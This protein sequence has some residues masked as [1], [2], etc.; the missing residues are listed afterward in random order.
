VIYFKKKLLVVPLIT[1]YPEY[2]GTNKYEEAIAFIAKKFESKHTR[3]KIF[4]HFTSFLDLNSTQQVFDTIESIVIVRN[5]EDTGLELTDIGHFDKHFQTS[6]IEYLQNDFENLTSISYEKVNFIIQQVKEK[7]GISLLEKETPILYYNSLLSR[8]E[9]ELLIQ[10]IE[11]QGKVRNK[12][13]INDF[14]FEIE[15]EELIRL[16]GSTRV[17]YLTKIFESSIFHIKFRRVK[18]QNK[19]INFHLDYAIKTLQISL[20]DDNEYIGGK[21]IFALE[22]KGFYSPKRHAGFGSIH[23]HTIVH[24]VSTLVSGTRYGLFFLAK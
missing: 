7:K 8:T 6:G 20:N 10:Y 11:N 16:L 13:V 15:K 24:G 3:Q 1:S 18:E 22:K 5:S 9:C 2:T 23:D 21:L 19:C 12:E 14:Q 4:S 17:N